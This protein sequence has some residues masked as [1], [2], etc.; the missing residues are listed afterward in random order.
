MPIGL[1]TV[2]EMSVDK[3]TVDDMSAKKNIA[4]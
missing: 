4:N 2:Y 1:I 3:M